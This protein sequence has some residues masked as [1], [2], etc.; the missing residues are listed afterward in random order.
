MFGLSHISVEI[1]MAHTITL[2]GYRSRGECLS[3]DLECVLIKT[4]SLLDPSNG[5]TLS[6]PMSAEIYGILALNSR[7]LE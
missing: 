6:T 4:L 2:Q 3:Q 5:S 1:I 7:Q